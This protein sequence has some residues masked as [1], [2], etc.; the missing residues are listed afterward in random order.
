M[1]KL[2]SLIP[3]PSPV[4]PGVPP[5]LAITFASSPLEPTLRSW[6][7][8]HHL[9]QHGGQRC[10]FLALP[11]DR[12]GQPLLRMPTFSQGL[13]FLT[14]AL[15]AKMGNYRGAGKH[16]RVAT[17][18]S[19]A[20]R[21]GFGSRFYFPAVETGHIVEPQSLGFFVFPRIIPSL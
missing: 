11:E 12:P 14:V 17:G 9:Y 8:A 19:E 3:L 5:N 18:D 2:S 16:G 20:R 13:N 6:T 7:G 10:D 4:N 21:C 15:R 1:G